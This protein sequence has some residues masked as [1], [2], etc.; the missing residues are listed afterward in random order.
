MRCIS[1]SLD[2]EASGK[3]RRRLFTGSRTRLDFAMI[4]TVEEGF[5]AA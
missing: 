3:V 1:N 2:A 4:H 5:V